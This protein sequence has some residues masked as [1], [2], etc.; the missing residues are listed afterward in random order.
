MQSTNCDKRLGVY[1]DF[2][3][4]GIIF[5]DFWPIFQDATAKK[6]LGDLL[7]DFYKDKKIDVVAGYE[8]R[9]IPPAMLLAERFNIGFVPLRKPGKL[10]GETLS[11]TYGKEYGKDTLYLQK[12]A[13]EP[14]QRVLLVD[15]LIATGGTA[16]AGVKLV[17]QAGAEPVGFFSVLEVKGQGG[18][19]KVE[20]TGVPT[21]NLV[22]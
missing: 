15:D 10:P 19:A 2:P 22:E 14:G 4:P 6:T 7:Y 18:R 11:E 5:Q 3:K 1:P 8:L 17:K 12:G 16:V 21:F 20:E 13:L 9:G